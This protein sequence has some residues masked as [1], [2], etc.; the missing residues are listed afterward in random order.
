MPPETPTTALTTALTTEQVRAALAA[1]LGEGDVDVALVAA[2]LGT[3]PRT[4]QRR[5]RAEGTSYGALL[6]AVRRERAEELVG[7]HRLT[8]CDVAVLLGLGSQA[9]LS[10][11]ARRWW[12]TTASARR[13]GTAG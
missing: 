11:A 8:L 3:G 4:L 12:G 6:D 5:L 2:A 1:S 10:R 7:D 13:L 9:T